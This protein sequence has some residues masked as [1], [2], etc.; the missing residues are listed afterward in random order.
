MQ[1]GMCN[2][3]R[4]H[5]FCEIAFNVERLIEVKQDELFKGVSFFRL[6]AI[7]FDG[8]EPLV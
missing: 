6:V 4:G 5:Y 3:G 8:A 7:L 2:F 1:I